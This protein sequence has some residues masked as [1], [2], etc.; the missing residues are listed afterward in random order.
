MHGKIPTLKISLIQIFRAHL[1]QKIHESIVMDL[2]Q[3]FDQEL[4]ALEIET[5][6][7]ETIHPRKSYKMNSS[8]ADI[9]LFA[10]YKWN[11]SRPSLLADSKDVMDSTTTQ[12]Y[13]IDIQLRWGDY[14]S[15]DIERYARAKFLDYTTDNMSIYP[16][17]TGVLIAI[18]LAYNLHS[19]YGNWFP[20][21]KPLIQQAMAKIMKA[22]PALYVL[23]E[24]IRKGLQLY[25]SE[26]TEPYLSSQNY[27]E[28]FSN[29][30]IWFVDD[31][32][33]YRVTIHKTFEG[34]LTTKPINGA[35]FIFN[36]R[37]G[38]LFLKI[39]HT[40][41]WAGQKRLGQL[42]KWKTAEEVAALIRSLP[43]EEQPKQIIV[44]R[45][46]M[47]DP[48]EV[49][50]LDFPNIVIKGS[51]LQ[52]PFQACLKVE[53]FGDLILK[54]TE[55]QMVLFNLYDD[56]LKTISSYTAFSRLILILRA[57]HVNNDRAKV[58][59]K[60]DKT[61]I[62]EPHHIW[63][64]LTDEEWIK[65]EVQLKDLILADYGK[66]N[67]SEV[68]QEI[69]LEMPIEESVNVASLTQSEIRD[70]ILGME[71]SAPSQQRQQIAEIEK[72]TKE[73]S[74]L[75]ATQTRTVNKHGD[76][77][78]TSTTSNYETQTFS[79]KT[80]WRVRAIS[81][82]NLHL[83]TNHIYV[84]S[85]DIKETGYTY[86]LPKNVLKK[87]ICISD[88]RAQIAGYLYGVSPPDNPQ[89]KEIRCIVMVPQWGTHQTVHL[90]GQLPQHEYL[91]EMEPLGWIHTQP[92]ESP[93]LSPQDVTTHAKIMADNPSW[94]GEKTI[95]ITC[96]FTPGSC[97]LTAY[98][99][100]PSGYEWGRQ[101]TDKG[102]NPKG[103]LPSHYERVQMLLSD[104]FLGFF[105][106]PA[107][108]SWNYNFMGVR[109]DPNM[110]Y[111]LQLAN[112]KEFYHEVHRP[113]HFLNFALLQEGE[114][115]SA[116]REDLYA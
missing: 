52:L 59:L 87:F 83:R 88:L 43:V 108:S 32:N 114:V 49:H 8:C 9:L 95:I 50:L 63:P 2:C 86:I 82:A 65:V 55:P 27:G 21:S 103:Y 92:N 16:S 115:Y 113:S 51:E 89:V 10:S 12:K 68:S 64:T 71:I 3:V 47:L 58:I 81:A 35:I 25:S 15:H 96:S 7:K 28:L 26:P 38:Q 77:I 66:K 45:K 41:V 39:I 19:A 36:P 72:Q 79:S 29:Q 90:P 17:P 46:G 104:R 13:W 110:K 33:V 97:T 34:N 67:N 100:T 53:K 54:A 80:E 5:V 109:H 37:T 42:A 1:W 30:I 20:G 78:I 91:K 48:L 60:P 75:T 6:Q 102:N 14:D 11:V 74:Q 61:T 76:E 105:M 24:R 57:L 31:T 69:V 94:D 70:I 73:Q 107:Q 62:T 101:N 84:S 93:Q 112:P 111:E 85:D 4:D 99:L 56:W 40:S 23:R 18:D 44:T 98:K 116:D 106:V 22:N